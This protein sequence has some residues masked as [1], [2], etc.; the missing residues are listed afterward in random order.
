LRRFIVEYQGVTDETN[1]LGAVRQANLDET[2]FKYVGFYNIAVS[3]RHGR[4]VY[5]PPPKKP[6]QNWNDWK[7]SAQRSA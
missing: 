6:K 3:D 7:S 4:T 5:L 2:K 1:I